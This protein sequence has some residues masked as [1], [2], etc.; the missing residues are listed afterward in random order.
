LHKIW[1]ISPDHS[2]QSTTP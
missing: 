1:W 2:D